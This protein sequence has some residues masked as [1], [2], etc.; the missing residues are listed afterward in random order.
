MKI[1]YFAF[2]VVFL[3]LS[4]G[5]KLKF[6][7][8]NHIIADNNF[9]EQ[10]SEHLPAYKEYDSILS[11]SAKMDKPILLYFTGHAVVNVIKM[12]MQVLKDESITNYMKNN[13]IILELHVDDRTELGEDDWITN[14]ENREVLKTVG[15]QNQHIQNI[16]FNR[17]TQ[18]FFVIMDSN[19]KIYGKT[20]YVPS[21]ENFNTFLSESFDR[22]KK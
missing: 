5:F 20:G 14:P 22:I 3:S 21:I 7:N 10:L 13:F 4:M 16:K 12:E 1:K 19:E 11:L 17:N 2:L 18:P 15:Q 9:T 8:K 6:N